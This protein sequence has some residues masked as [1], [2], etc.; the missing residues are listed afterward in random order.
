MA[1]IS[2]QGTTV[3]GAA[4]GLSPGVAVRARVSTAPLW[5]LYAALAAFVLFATGLV[6]LAPEALNGTLTPHVLAL[7][8]VATLGLLTTA[9]MGA[10]WQLL[11]VILVVPAPASWLAR[12][13]FPLWVGGVALLVA[14]FWSA[15][16]PA[17]AAGGTLVVLGALFF[18]GVMWG[19][20]ARAPRRP[21]SAYFVAASLLDLVLVVLGGLAL[22]VDLQTGVLGAWFVRVLP[23]HLLLGLVGWGVGTVL[24][25]SYK[26]APMFALAHLGDERPGWVCFGLFNSGLVGLAASLLAGW[27]A[28]VGFACAALILLALLVFALDT[29]RLLRARHKKALE[30]TQWH[31]LSG[32]AALLLC[33]GGSLGAALGGEDWWLDGRTATVLGL[34]FLLGFVGQTILGY[35]Y[36]IVPFLVWNHRYAPLVG[37]QAVPLM[38]DL[39]QQRVASRTF[40][41]YNAGL[42]ALLAALLWAPQASGPAAAV[43]AL[44]TWIAGANLAWVLRRQIALSRPR[45]QNE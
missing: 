12:A 40:F 4:A 25:V 19:T 37:R 41:L 45:T 20:I 9:I 24:G 43:V 44:A 34:L 3:G 42:V 33:G 8:H 13:H 36:K 17:L 29:L 5:Y 6:P 15:W 23:A 10:L 30:P 31:A 27:P 39:V 18:A 2:K 38:R 22:A 7:V 35:L 11:P 14:G 32:L 28:P 26:L 21:L 16:W 1:T